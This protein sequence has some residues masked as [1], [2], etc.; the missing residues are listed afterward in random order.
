MEHTG[1][2]NAPSSRDAFIAA[3][4][5]LLR[6][7]GYAATGL[8]EIVALSGAPKGSLYFHFP[9]GKDELA[10]LAM[11]HAGE[12]LTVAIQAVLASSP[13]PAEGVGRL[14]DALGAG[15]EASG[16]ADGCPI[17]TVAL[18]SSAESELLRATAAGVFGA[19]TDAL[20]ERLLASGMDPGGAERRAMFALSAIEG[21][22][23]L[24]R[25]RRD[26]APLHAVREELVALAG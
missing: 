8:N 24:A 21:A 1:S 23:I 22:L 11:A 4:A 7:Q 6:R 9:G 18:E 16:Y 13:T 25:V 3:T 15:L 19:W 12:E 14:I 17:A 10:A 5:R 2:S 20:R 26:V